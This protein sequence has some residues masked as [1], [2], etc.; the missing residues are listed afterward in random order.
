MRRNSK[1]KTARLNAN[2]LRDC[3]SDLRAKKAAFL[4]LPNLL[5]EQ[6]H[7][8]MFLP[9]SVDR[10]VATLDGLIAESPSAGRRFLSRFQTKKPSHDIPIALYNE[11][12]RDDE[13][14]FLLAPMLQ[15]QRWGLISDAGMP[16]IADP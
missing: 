5:G 4:L 16:C 2:Y 6:A 9:G 14:D 13:L 11:H 10:A 7:H 1:P 15:G 8:E 3:L 12:T